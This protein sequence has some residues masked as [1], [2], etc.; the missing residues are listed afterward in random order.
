MIAP[1]V[2]AAGIAS[3]ANILGG[4][5]GN[6]GNR[7]EAEKD[8]TFQ[9]SEAARQMMFQER[10][11]STEWQAGVEDMKKAGL[12][13]ALA[14]SQGGASSP[15]GAR[16]AGSRATQQDILS[17]AVSSALGY[18]RAAAEIKGINAAAEKTVAETAQ[19]EGRVTRAL[20]PGVSVIEKAIDDLVGGRVFTP[21]NRQILG[22]EM[23]VSARAVAAGAK[24]FIG[25]ITRRARNF[26]GIGGRRQPRSR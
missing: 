18:A 26:V 20:E 3:G 9:S 4:M 16:G 13:P 2:A 14:Y 22:H 24:N 25:E 15:G 19:V 23:G 7:Q 17:P 21:A 10:M 1:M 8:R 12:N 11:R 6:R 5:M